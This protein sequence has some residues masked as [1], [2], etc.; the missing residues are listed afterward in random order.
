MTMKMCCRSSL[1]SVILLL[2]IAASMIACKKGI[3][4]IKGKGDTVTQNWQLPS[5]KGIQLAN[6]AN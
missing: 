3:F 4:C 2:S 1:L 6:S 5:F